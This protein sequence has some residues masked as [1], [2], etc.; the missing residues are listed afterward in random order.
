MRARFIMSLI[1]LSASQLAGAQLTEPT[2]QQMID[3][4]SKM[5]R[6]RS[7]RNLSIE[8]IKD[9]STQTDPIAGQNSASAV[10]KQIF[11]ATTNPI[12]SA[13]EP[14][15][16]LNI[17][18]EFG[19]ARVLPAS[20]AALEN[21]STALTS[22]ALS[23]SNF[24]IEGHTDAKGSSDINLKLSQ[25]R[26]QAVLA[27]LIAKGVAHTRLTA[28]GMGSNDLAEKSDPFSAN[29]RRVRI[30]NKD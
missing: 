20:H 21:L 26:A 17:L 8:P 16:S 14:S 9:T 29:N 28:V 3:Q 30:V 6:T 25:Q 7:M 1:F 23:Q 19:S 27:V 2:T 10:P 13:P 12:T 15:L 22:S 24:L 11:S 5:P 4:L 18:F